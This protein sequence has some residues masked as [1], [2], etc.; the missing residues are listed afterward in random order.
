MS[1]IIGTG[2]WCDPDEGVIPG[3]KYQGDSVIRQR[4]FHKLWYESLDRFT[5]PDKIIIVDS[6]SP[7]KPALL[8]D[9][10][11]EYLTLNHNPGHPTVHKGLYSGW[12]ASVLCGL[13]YALCCDTHYFVYVEQDALLYGERIVEHCIAQMRTP[14]MFGAGLGTPQPLQQSFFIIRRDGMQEFLAGLH[15]I[16]ERD[17]EVSPERKFALACN[18]RARQLAAYKW[19]HISSIP[20]IGKLFRQLVYNHGY[21]TLPIGGGRARP[22]PFDDPFF[23]FQHGTVTEIEQYVRRTSATVDEDRTASLLSR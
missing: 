20:R 13:E 19:P 17:A 9:N 1:Y 7:V 4:E 23:Y 8:S 10:R 11:I 18:R 14:Y 3:R 16:R 22:V 15:S 6:A 21:D 12:T 5:N 2:W